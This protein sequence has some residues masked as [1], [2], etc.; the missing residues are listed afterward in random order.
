MTEVGQDAQQV[1]DGYVI[2]AQIVF[3]LHEIAQCEEK[4]WHRKGK[5]V[6]SHVQQVVIAEQKPHKTE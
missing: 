2:Q 6:E 5:T 3:V 4:Q 1:E